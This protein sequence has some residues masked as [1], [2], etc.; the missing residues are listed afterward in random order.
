MS[1]SAIVTGA[2]RGLGLCIAKLLVADGYT[3]F[4]VSKTKKGWVQ[5]RKALSDPKRFILD[6][7]DITSESKVASYVK[8]ILKINP[9]LS[10]LIN[11]AGY[12]SPMQFVEQTTFSDL[13]KHLTHN[14]ASQFL[15]CKYI[16]PHFQ[17]I[18]RG[19][20][21]NISSMA[22]KRAVPKLFGY[23]ASKFGVLA[24]SQCI[25]KE[26]LGHNIK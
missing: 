21:V 2:S 17:R 16:L 6:Q 12:T 26:N 18:H 8:R 9:Q 22:G 19:M 3:V 1:H 25:A 7:V 5:A 14:L 4:G 13:L 10:L 15:M 24:L 20:I 23:S 11:N